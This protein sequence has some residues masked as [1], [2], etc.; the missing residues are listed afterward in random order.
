VRVGNLPQSCRIHI[1]ELLG[2]K[3]NNDIGNALESTHSLLVE[4]ILHTLSQ[5]NWGPYSIHMLPYEG[6]NHRTCGGQ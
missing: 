6:C 2:G 3:R 4:N 5:P 1:L